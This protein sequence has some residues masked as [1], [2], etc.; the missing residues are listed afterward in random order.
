MT[1]NYPTA[2]LLTPKQ[3]IRVGCWNVRT[4]YQAG[5]LA[6]AAK[7]MD[8]YNISLLGMSE[9]RWTGTGKQRLNSGGVMIWSGRS[10]N[11]HHEGVALLVSKKHANTILQWKPV[12]ERLLYVRL[13]S[14]YAKLSIVV[15]YAPIDNAEEETKD[16]FYSSLQA[17]LDY[18]PRHDVTMLL[19]DFNA[20]VGQNSHNRS[21]VMGTHALGDITDNGERLV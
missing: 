3:H 12:N 11:I 18:I 4:L 1:A 5:R 16:T 20:R 6:Q 9:V 21:R 2:D 15:A 13:N 10:D 19:G 7:E 14:K 8:R 17:V